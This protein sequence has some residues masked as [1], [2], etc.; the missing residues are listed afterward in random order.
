[1]TFVGHVLMIARCGCIVGSHSA[2]VVAEDHV[3][4][5]VAGRSRS[6]NGLGYRPYLM[7]Q[8]NQPSDVEPHLAIDL[9]A[10]FALALDHDDP[11]QAEPIESLIVN[12]GDLSVSIR[13]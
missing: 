13:P 5:P 8:Q 10:D 6:P 2:F 3:Q 12:D 7:D 1:M 4:H 9:A 11:L